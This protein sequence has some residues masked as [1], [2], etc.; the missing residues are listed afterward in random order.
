MKPNYKQTFT[1]TQKFI[2]TTQSKQALDILKMDYSEVM[3]LIIKSAQKN[4]FIDISFHH[5][6]TYDLFDT[7]SIKKTLKE[8]LY[9]QLHTNRKP[10][11]YEICSFIIESLDNDGF[12]TYSVDTYCKLLKVPLEVFKKN[13]SFLQTFD[14]C[15]VCATNT[16]EAMILQC[17]RM[18]DMHGAYLLTHHIE[19]IISRKFTKIAKSM[20]VS[21]SQIKE[22]ISALQRCRPNPCLAYEKEPIQYATPEVDII[23]QDEEISVSPVKF[24]GVYLNEQ[25]LDF[26]SENPNLKTYFQEAS[27]LFETLHKR[28]ATLLMVVNELVQIQKSYF[29]YQDE[30][31]PCT[32]KDIAITLGIS[33]STVSRTLA[34]KYFR[35]REEIYPFKKLFVSTSLNGDSS[36]SIRKALLQLIKQEDKEKPLSDQQI[37]IKLSSMDIITSR[38][39]IAKYRDQLK[40]MNSTERKQLK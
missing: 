12:L 8:D 2:L 23:V 6:D 14:P 34:K 39:T 36:D 30:L 5:E 28:N 22:Y 33:E 7:I 31:N 1:Y 24:E 13:L 38:R 19:D 25:Y 32:L 37:V 4:P 9:Y 10:C 27:I 26:I 15:G 11:D 16:I 21:V 17:N 40:I 3:K 20:N 29:L 18:G 35:F